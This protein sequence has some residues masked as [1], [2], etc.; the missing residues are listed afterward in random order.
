MLL[1]MRW[2][3]VSVSDVLLHQLSLERL[4]SARVDIIAVMRH[5]CNLELT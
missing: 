4:S 3:V 5:I 2:V 1:P